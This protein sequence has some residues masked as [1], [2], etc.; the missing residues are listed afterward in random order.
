MPT[1]DQTH[2]EAKGKVEQN[3]SRVL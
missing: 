3:E 1:T 2:V